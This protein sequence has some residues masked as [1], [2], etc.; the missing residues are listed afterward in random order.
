MSPELRNQPRKRFPPDDPREWLNRARSNL[1][2]AEQGIEIPDVYLEDLCFN[3]QQAAEKAL[4]AVLIE[5]ELEFPYVHDLVKLMETLLQGGHDVPDKVREAACIS[6]YAVAARYPGSLDPSH[7]KTTKKRLSLPQPWFA[8]QR[9]S[10]A[11]TVQKRA[12]CTALTPSPSSSRRIT[13]QS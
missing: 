13:K 8:G 2:Q 10:L 7:D 3:A 6:Q 1:A 9:M 5:H 12:E 11:A 4:K